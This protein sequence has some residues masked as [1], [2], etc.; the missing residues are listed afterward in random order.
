[1]IAVGWPCGLGA[2]DDASV[3]IQ[4][5]RMG[6]FNC[7]ILTSLTKVNIFNYIRKFM[8][9]TPAH[10]QPMDNICFTTLDDADLIKQTQDKTNLK[11]ITINGDFITSKF[12]FKSEV[13][14]PP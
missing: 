11:S 12:K 5:G 3:A 6:I 10:Q 8:A 7:Y 4:F 14:Y 1:M 9:E 2:Y 13:V